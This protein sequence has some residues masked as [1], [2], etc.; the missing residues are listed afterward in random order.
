M[1]RVEDIV[2][3]QINANAKQ[4]PSETLNET[5][6]FFGRGGGGVGGRVNLKAIGKQRRISL[7]NRRQTSENPSDNIREVFR[8]LEEM[9]HLYLH[10]PIN[11]PKF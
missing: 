9:V 4:I 11:Y 5:M 10:L 6:T 8:N 2:A 7:D 1:E 3:K